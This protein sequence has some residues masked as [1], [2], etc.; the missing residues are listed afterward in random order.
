MDIAL[1]HQAFHELWKHFEL[2]SKPLALNVLPQ[3]VLLD[4]RRA[5]EAR[6]WDELRGIGIDDRDR[7][8]DLR[9][10]LL[11]LHQHDH[12]F[13]LTYRYLH[14]GQ[15]RRKAGLVATDR[16][17]A[18]L[19]VHDTDHVR[20]V[21][22]RPDAMIRA[23]LDVLPE[24]KA[25]PGKGVS[26]RSADLDQVAAE[27]GTSNRAVQEGLVRRGVR[28]DDVRALVEMAGQQRIAFAQFGAAVM[29]GTGHRRRAAAVT[30]CFATAQGWYFMEESTRGSEPWTTFAPVDG[31]R[32]GA[33]IQDL[34]KT[35]PR[36]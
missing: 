33:R 28:R 16:H 1:S 18:T 24:L 15:D 35:V 2:G 6:A 20:L 9:A 13:D 29:D 22:T 3:G 21:A 30:N 32:M 27:A 36:D 26:L 10:A 25:G 17:N 34:L 23:L 11:P 14:D 12:A 5:A 19:A 8:D 4:E 31:S 7:S